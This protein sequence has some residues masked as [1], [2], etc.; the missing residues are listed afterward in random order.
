MEYLAPREMFRL[1]LCSKELMN[2]VTTK[3]VV[4]SALLQE[5][6]AKTIIQT[7]APLIKNRSICVPTPLLLLR[8]LNGKQCER[9]GKKFRHVRG[10]ANFICSVC[11]TRCFR[12]LYYK[13]NMPI[14]FWP[15][16]TCVS[17]MPI[18]FWPSKS[19]TRGRRRLRKSEKRK[20]VKEDEKKK[21]RKN[22]MRILRQQNHVQK[23]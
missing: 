11:N 10:F 6:Q 5:G 14:S 19:S 17:N 23:C 21:N 4:R 1:A 18:S 16:T 2:S 8:L 7:I 3:M 12:P 20:Q 9:F 15:A 13:S 22:A